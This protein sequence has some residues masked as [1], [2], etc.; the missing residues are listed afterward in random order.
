MLAAQ[1]LLA[2]TLIG[3]WLESALGSDKT[4]PLE[5]S[6]AS[7]SCNNNAPSSSIWSLPDEKLILGRL[8]HRM[9]VA[10]TTG[11]HISL[12][13]AEMFHE[14]RLALGMLTWLQAIEPHQ[15]INSIASYL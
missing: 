10:D 4:C 7:I 2:C 15:V 6:D 5:D 11:V 8:P 1:T 14:D 12:K 9:S 3:T 13:T